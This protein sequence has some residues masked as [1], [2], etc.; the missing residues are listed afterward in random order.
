MEKVSGS[1][2]YMQ[3]FA[4]K[5]RKPCCLQEFAS[6]KLRPLRV[7]RRKRNH[8]GRECVKLVIRISSKVRAHPVKTDMGVGTW[9]SGLL[10][11]WGIVPGIPAAVQEQRN[12]AGCC[13]TYVN[14]QCSFLCFN[15][16]TSTKAGK[17]GQGYSNVQHLLKC[18]S[19]ARPPLLTPLQQKKS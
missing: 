1:S 9:W 19:R 11:F 3:I 18:F 7:Y 2:V 16:G 13:H 17:W 6:Q 4:A 5:V 8:G 10:V 15:E 12:R 14:H